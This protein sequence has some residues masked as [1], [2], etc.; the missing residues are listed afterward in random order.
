M[1]AS[2]LRSRSITVKCSVS[3]LS[4]VLK[5]R[6]GVLPSDRVGEHDKKLTDGEV[7]RSHILFYAFDKDII[8][9]RLKLYFP[10]TNVH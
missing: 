6:G 8:L 1:R 2:V 9:K 3:F 10:R 5:D 7:S 4:N